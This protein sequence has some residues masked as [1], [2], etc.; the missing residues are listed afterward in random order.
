M[1][2]LEAQI[3][4]AVEENIEETASDEV[5][6]YDAEGNVVDFS[7]YYDENGNRIASAKLGDIVTV[8]ISARARGTSYLP[9]I[10][11]TDL[12]PGGFVAEDVTGP[13]TFSEIREDIARLYAAGYFA[14][15]ALYTAQDAETDTSLL[16]ELV[17]ESFMKLSDG[18]PVNDIKPV[19]EFVVAR[20]LGITPCLEAEQ[21]STAYYFSI[22]DGRLYLSP[23]PNSV[24]VTRKVVMSVYK[25]ITS[26]VKQ[27]LEV[28]SEDVESF[29]KLAEQ[30]ILYHT[31]HNFE[32]LKYLNG[33]I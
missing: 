29:Y 28:K 13:Q 24:Y 18:V 5:V 19:F 21:K 3:Q 30:Y 20:L 2:E 33:V 32:N 1:E 6:Y 25:V 22:D 9:D 26:T 16:M 12:L 27:A 31:D 10:A 23:V 7:Q 4:P 14:S 15:L 17:Y 11:I 8:K